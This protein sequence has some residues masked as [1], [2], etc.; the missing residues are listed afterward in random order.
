MRGRKT[1]VLPELSEV[2]GVQFFREIVA[3]YRPNTY[4]GD[5]WA[6]FSQQVVQHG[7][8]RVAAA[9][10]GGLLPRHIIQVFD[11]ALGSAIQ[12]GSNQVTEDAV[13]KGVEKVVANPDSDSG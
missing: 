5:P 10:N 13:E 2:E 6:P 7:V 1:L 8:S 4:T 11:N 12:D 3:F 9:K